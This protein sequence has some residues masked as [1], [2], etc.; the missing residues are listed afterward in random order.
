MS[1]LISEENKNIEDD[2]LIPIIEDPAKGTREKTSIIRRIVS[3]HFSGPLPPPEVMKRY[4]EILPGSAERILKMAEN[5]SEHRMSLE[6]IVIP[7]QQKESARGQI[8]GFVL[9][10][11]LMVC[12]V[13]AIA[14]G[15]GWIGGMILTVTIVSI[16]TLFIAGRRHNRK[17]LDEKSRN[18]D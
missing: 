11:L 4:E 12:A 7:R 13:Y 8:F 3:E 18:E 10:F 2:V 1:E 5:Q 17:D 9:S 16:A 6:K 15:F 14:S